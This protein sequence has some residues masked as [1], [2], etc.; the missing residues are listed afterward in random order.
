M[1]KITSTTELD[2]D[3]YYEIFGA[4]TPDKIVEAGLFSDRT[5]VVDKVNYSTRI[6]AS[7]LEDLKALAS[8]IGETPS[9]LGGQLLVSALIQ[10]RNHFESITGELPLDDPEG[11]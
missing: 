8:A 7:A 6:P 1:G 10:A 4:R 9:S 5:P 11:K 3:T 2:H